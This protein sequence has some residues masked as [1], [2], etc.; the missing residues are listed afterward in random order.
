MKYDTARTRISVTAKMGFQG[1][2]NPSLNDGSPL[3]F[4]TESD[5]FGTHR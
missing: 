1:S 4:P 5:E 3:G 2:A